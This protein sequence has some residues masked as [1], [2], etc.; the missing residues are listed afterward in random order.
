MIISST[1]SVIATRALFYTQ[2]IAT[3][4]MQ[5]PHIYFTYINIMYKNTPPTHII[6]MIQTQT[7][8]YNIPYIAHTHNTQYMLSTDTHNTH[9]MCIYTQAFTPPHTHTQ[10]TT[11]KPHRHHRHTPHLHLFRKCTKSPIFRLDF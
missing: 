7:S 2:D 9:V 10:T 5:I 3:L 6:Y 4:H 11:T 8:G 1:I